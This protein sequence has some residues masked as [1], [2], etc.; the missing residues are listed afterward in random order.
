MAVDAP[1]SPIVGGGEPSKS[2]RAAAVGRELHRYC[3]K[4]LFAAAVLGVAFV[5]GNGLVT[6]ATNVHE[7]PFKDGQSF[8]VVG[9]GPG[10]AKG[11]KYGAFIDSH[12]VVVRFN[13]VVLDPAEYTGNRTDL[14]VITAGSPKQHIEGAFGVVVYSSWIHDKLAEWAH[15]FTFPLH[16]WGAKFNEDMGTVGP[17]SG[18]LVTK[19]LSEVRDT[20]PA[21]PDG[22]LPSPHLPTTESRR[23]P[24]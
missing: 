4:P 23:I 19:F 13:T 10:V 15:P 22:P 11:E 17:S 3:L 16:A 1:T 8:V 12:D 20:P 14:H 21:V 7:L 18:L 6:R 2:G 9:N 24:L 5:Y